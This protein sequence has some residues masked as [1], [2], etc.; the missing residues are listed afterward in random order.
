MK[1]RSEFFALM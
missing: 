1:A